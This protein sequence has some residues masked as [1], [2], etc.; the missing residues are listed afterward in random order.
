MC[1]NIPVHTKVSFSVVFFM[2][3]LFFSQSLC[4]GGG[5]SFSA[6][7]LIKRDSQFNYFYSGAHPRESSTFSLSSYIFYLVSAFLSI[8]LPWLFGLP[9]L[10]SLISLYCI[11][12][13]HSYSP[14]S[15]VL[16]HTTAP[17]YFPLESCEH[18]HFGCLPF[19]ISRATVTAIISM[20]ISLAS[21]INKSSLTDTQ[22]SA[23]EEWTRLFFII[24]SLT[25]SL[26]FPRAGPLG[27][28]A[29][30]IQ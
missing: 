18:K 30:R 28:E 10:T 13:P 11:A 24:A 9:H 8:F 23:S 19:E 26:F 25:P 14:F 29:S 5:D 22:S 2:C 7:V 21:V 20:L 3:A 6:E 15:L 16:F 4:V 1:I 27:S 12:L 17:L